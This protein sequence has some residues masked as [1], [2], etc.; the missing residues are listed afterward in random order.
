MGCLSRR[1]R[2]LAE[3]AETP[4]IEA[5][6]RPSEGL[7]H[8]LPSLAQDA[9][10]GPPRPLARRDAS[11]RRRDAG[12]G[13]LER[14]PGRPT[15]AD[16]GSVRSR[17]GDRVTSGERNPRGA[18]PSPPGRD[19]FVLPR[20]LQEGHQATGGTRVLSNRPHPAWEIAPPGVEGIEALVP[21]AGP[22]PRWAT[23]RELMGA[24][25]PIE[26][27]IV[28]QALGHPKL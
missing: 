18:R 7:T 5:S 12:S 14:V 23:D 9:G 26:T 28:S 1:F 20:A 22:V 11:A 13:S 3:H 4:P 16:R 17:V 19:G 27:A 6:F 2:Q 24:F 21:S 15:R 25:V 10:D 8:A